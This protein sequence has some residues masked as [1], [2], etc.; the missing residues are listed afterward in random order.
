MFA[1]INGVSVHYE[2]LGDDNNQPVLLLHGWGCNIDLMM[3][4]AKALQDRMC[5]YILDFPGF[6]KSDRPPQP[7]GVPEYA[8]CVKEFAR[9]IIGKSFAVV[10]HSFGCRV[11]A[12][13]AHENPE[14]ITKLVFTGAAGIRKKVTQ[15]DNRKTRRYKRM[16]AF[17]EKLEQVKVLPELHKKTA[18]KIRKIIVEKYGSAD[19]KALDEEMRKTFVKVINLDLHDL[20][21]E[22][23]QP[24]LLIWGADDTETPLWMGKEMEKLIPDSGLVIFENGTHFAYL[25]QSERFNRIVATFLTED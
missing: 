18:R 25:E 20:Y 3:P 19:Y 4:A 6:G 2:K 5:V 22:I 10:G 17:A 15:E 9:Q 1:L 11:A 23:K 13:L 12:W 16:K 8:A 24:T 7:W 21:S 14:T